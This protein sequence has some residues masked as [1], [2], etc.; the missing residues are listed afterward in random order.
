MRP[1][2][3]GGNFVVTAASPTTAEDPWAV[4]FPTI[5]YVAVTIGAALVPFLAQ[6][7]SRETLGAVASRIVWVVAFL[8][9]M[10]TVSLPGRFDGLQV[11]AQKSKQQ[12]RNNFKGGIPWTPVFAP[13]GWAFAIWGIIYAGELL[14][15]VAIG[16]GC[17]DSVLDSLPFWVAANLFQSLW[18]GSFRPSFA[19]HLYIPSILLALAATSQLWCHAE[20]TSVIDSS[21]SLWKKCGL[22]LFRFPVALHAGWLCAACLLNLNGWAARSKLEMGTQVALAMASTYVATALAAVL[23]FVRGDPFLA[24]TVAWALK[25]VS[26][27]TRS[28]SAAETINLPVVAKE[29]LALTE[30]FFSSLLIGVGVVAPLFR[31]EIRNFDL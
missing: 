18:C 7:L 22:L 17:M 9:N 15:T 19:N 11:E 24:L 1:P 30:G 27:Q 6:G 4:G 31:R 8:I 2:S 21:T 3:S 14:A 12:G 13:A 16:L 28:Q 5:Q 25:A 20:I 23:T 26:L 10:L 29:A